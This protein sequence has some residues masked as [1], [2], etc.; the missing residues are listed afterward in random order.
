[1]Q[2][3]DGIKLSKTEA[4]WRVVSYF[5]HRRPTETTNIALGDYGLHTRPEALPTIHEMETPCDF[6]PCTRIH[7][8]ALSIPTKAEFHT[9]FEGAFQ[10]S[11]LED[12]RW[13]QESQFW[14][15]HGWELAREVGN[16]GHVGK[17]GQ[18]AAFHRATISRL[19]RNCK[20]LT[21]WLI[22]H[23]ED[24]ETAQITLASAVHDHG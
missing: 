8:L 6:L 4:L 19:R 7:E 5:E 16:Q 23:N 2:E 24:M 1:M 12:K 14:Q 9:Y 13:E 11:G 21:E 15:N 22:Q 20:P 10:I 18:L 17:A 3:D